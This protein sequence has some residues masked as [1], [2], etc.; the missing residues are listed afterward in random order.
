MQ[1]IGTGT[2]KRGA[3][4]AKLVLELRLGH[5]LGSAEESQIG[6]QQLQQAAD[7]FGITPLFENEPDAFRALAAIVDDAGGDGRSDR[8]LQF[9]FAIEGKGEEVAVA[10]IAI[11]EL[12]AESG[13]SF[14]L[15]AASEQQLGRVHCAGANKYIRCFYGAFCHR[16][17]GL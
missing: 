17:D 2:G 16:H 1:T 5:Q 12:V 8:R 3:A 4:P 14:V 7:L 10:R 9:L 13:Q 15:V 6:I 11:A